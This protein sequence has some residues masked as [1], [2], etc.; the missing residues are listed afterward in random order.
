MA[1]N[2]RTNQMNFTHQWHV[3]HES[4]GEVRIHRP[5]GSIVCIV[6]GLRGCELVDEDARL[7]SAAPELLDALK[8]VLRIARAASIGITGNQPRIERAQAAIKKA[9]E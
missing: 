8:D 2:R 3:E 4:T 5:G 6:H 9:T 1:S 7:I